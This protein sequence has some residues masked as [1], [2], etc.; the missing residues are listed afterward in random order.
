M[1]SS[2][3]LAASSI[4]PLGILAGFFEGNFLLDRAQLAEYIFSTIRKNFH[5]AE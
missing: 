1:C 3:L 5:N 2:P 4:Q